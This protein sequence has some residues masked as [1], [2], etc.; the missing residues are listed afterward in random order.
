MGRH[1]MKGRQIV[2]AGLL[3]CGILIGC[4]A[5]PHHESTG[6]AIDDSAITTKIKTALI[7]DPQTK[8]RD[9]S[10]TTSQ[11]VVQLSGA[12][13]SASEREAAVHIARHEQGVRSVE[14]D[15]RVEPPQ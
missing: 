7:A 10:V 9:I 13:D 5:T 6:Q 3:L 11:G 8:A 4:A 12:V 14:D 15:L 1:T 2:P